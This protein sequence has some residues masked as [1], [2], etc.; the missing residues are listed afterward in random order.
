MNKFLKKINKKD[1]IYYIGL[2]IILLLNIIKLDYEI[3]SPGDL[4][5][6]ENRIDVEN[7]YESKGSI[8]LTYVTSRS[9]YLTN[10]LL[11]YIIPTW[12]LVSLDDS[13]IENES[14][15]EIFER[16]KILLKETSY[17]AIIS[18]FDAANISYEVKNINLVVTYIFEGS[19]TNL[20]I[21]DTIK[22]INGKTITSMDDISNEISNY[23][24][25]DKI[26]I[27]VLR[28]DKLIDCYSVLRNENNKLIIGIYI[29][30]LKDIETTPK[31]EYIF[32]DSESGSSRGLMCALDIYNK[33]TE[34]DITKGR[35]ISGT[36]TID[37]KGNVGSIAGVKYKIIGADK[38][39]ADIFIV[40][41]DNYEEALKAKKDNNLKIEIISVSTLK[42]LIEKLENWFYQFFYFEVVY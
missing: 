23:K 40:P 1:L 27:K 10:I 9:G 20:K 28:N 17:D 37:D 35:I 13:R 6:L 29:S 4:I 16:N 33:I 7:A 21:G 14:E 8:N 38:N 12:D 41:K 5:N 36:G 26:N 25:N 18:A 31:V 24:E 3:Y 15:K 39:K 34:K 30:K 11:S 42:E 2:I 22:E 32:K 19:D